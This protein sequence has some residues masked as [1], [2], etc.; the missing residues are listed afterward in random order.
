MAKKEGVMVPIF[1]GEADQ[2]AQDNTVAHMQAAME[3]LNA[4]FADGRKHAAGENITAADFRLLTIGTSIIE[5]KSLKIP[6]LQERLHEMAKG[7]ENIQRVVDN[8]KAIPGLQAEIEKAMALQS[9]I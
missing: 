3:G 4:R 7:L 1:N 8:A 9:W 2:A 5:N 6:A